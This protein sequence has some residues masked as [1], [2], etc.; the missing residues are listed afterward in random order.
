MRVKLTSSSSLWKKSVMPYEDDASL[1]LSIFYGLFIVLLA[2]VFKVSEKTSTPL[3][4]SVVRIV[5]S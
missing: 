1:M 2:M 3:S 4:V 5:L